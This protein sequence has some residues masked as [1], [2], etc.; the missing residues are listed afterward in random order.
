MCTNAYCALSSLIGFQLLSIPLWLRLVG[1]VGKYKAYLIWNMTLVITTAL[2][3]ID[4]S[5]DLSILPPLLI[6]HSVIYI[7]RYIYV[8]I[9]INVYIA[10]TLAASVHNI[11]TWLIGWLTYCGLLYAR[12]K[13]FGDFHKVELTTFLCVLWGIGTERTLLYI[14]LC[15]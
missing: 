9:Y 3:V 2:C 5:V 1:A 15:S 7:Y 10:Y 6:A 13:I 12:R 4:L 14:T 11:H 8:Y